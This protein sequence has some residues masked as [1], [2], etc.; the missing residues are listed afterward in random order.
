MGEKQVDKYLDSV[1]LNISKK[2]LY[3]MLAEALDDQGNNKEA[4][5]YF[6][7]SLWEYE[8]EKKPEIGRAHV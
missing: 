7:Q 8:Q 2:E 4:I 1:Q 5:R 6:M 3:Q